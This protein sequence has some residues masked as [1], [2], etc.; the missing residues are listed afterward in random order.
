VETYT[1]NY[2]TGMISWVCVCGCNYSYTWE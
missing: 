1:Y 2:E